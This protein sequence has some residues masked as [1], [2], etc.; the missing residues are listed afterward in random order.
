M[1][2]NGRQVLIANEF[3]AKTNFYCMFEYEDYIARIAEEYSN[4]YQISVSS[5]QSPV[6]DP[7]IHCAGIDKLTA[8]KMSIAE[9]FNSFMVGRR[10]LI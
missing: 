3:D 10:R 9:T 5:G 7:E 8:S 4:S 1:V 2:K 6:Y